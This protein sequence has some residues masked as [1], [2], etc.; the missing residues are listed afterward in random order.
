M[1][2]IGISGKIG[3]GKTT[4]ANHL[5]DKLGEGWRRL[6]YGDVMKREV[7]DKFHVPIKDCYEKKERLWPVGMYYRP[8]KGEGVALRAPYMS[9]RRLLQ[10]W[11]TDVRRG[12]DPDYWVSQM[13]EALRRA[14]IN[15]IQGVVVDDVRFENEAQLIKDLRGRLIRLNPYGEWVCDP[16]VAEHESETALDDYTGWDLNVYPG[17]GELEKLARG[18]IRL[19]EVYERTIVLRP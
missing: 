10:W 17:Y 4:L 14:K 9:I 6:A 16:K 8:D 11:G 18:V 5:V 13:R 7:S 2:V 1:Q 15:A 3:T 19:Q 12:Q